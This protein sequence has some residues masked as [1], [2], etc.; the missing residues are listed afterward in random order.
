MKKTWLITAL[1]VS[2]IALSAC[3]DD[4]TKPLPVGETNSIGEIVADNGEKEQVTQE[5]RNLFHNLI[6]IGA[7]KSEKEMKT[8][9]EENLYYPAEYLKTLVDNGLSIEYG[10]YKKATVAHREEVLK[11]ISKGHYIYEAYVAIDLQQDNSSETTTGYAEIKMELKE[12]DGSLKIA[13][14]DL[15]PSGE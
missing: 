3:S 7:D 15:R 14:L 2:M 5:A 4:K 8:I 1:C 9:V 10:N 12:R 11:Q 6:N 13:K